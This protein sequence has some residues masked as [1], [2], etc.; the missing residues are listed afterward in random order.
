MADICNMKLDFTKDEIKNIKDK[1]YLTELQE[2]ILDYKLKGDLTDS[3]IA[4]KLNVSESTVYYQWKKVK[5]KIL[6]VI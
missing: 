4:L 2:K 1:I 3:G 5:K 6:K